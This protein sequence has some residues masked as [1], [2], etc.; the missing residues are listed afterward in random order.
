MLK[1][2][3]HH[4]N[5]FFRSV[6][7]CQKNSGVWYFGGRKPVL[8]RGDHHLHVGPLFVH[9]MCEPEAVHLTWHIDVGEKKRDFRVL[10]EH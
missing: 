2:K 5:E 8:A 10:L 6:W 7:F 4:F 3:L 1:L 9:T